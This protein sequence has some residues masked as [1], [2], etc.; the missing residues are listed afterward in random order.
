MRR[1]T[2]PAEPSDAAGGGLHLETLD[3]GLAD[4]RYAIE[5][6]G[7]AAH[8]WITVDDPTKEG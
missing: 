6:S 8:L 2:S 4:D 7:G 5:I 1:S 3:A